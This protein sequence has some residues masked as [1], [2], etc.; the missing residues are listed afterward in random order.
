MFIYLAL[1]QSLAENLLVEDQNLA[2]NLLVGHHI[3]VE[4]HILVDNQ[5]VGILQGDLEVE[6]LVDILQAP[7]LVLEVLVVKM[8]MI[9]MEHHNHH[10][11]LVEL[12]FFVQV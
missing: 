2:R 11:Q 4:H 6:I 12:L 3:L 1:D 5:V 9:L 8:D 7:Y 10:H